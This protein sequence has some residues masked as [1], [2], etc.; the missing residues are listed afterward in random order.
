[1]LCRM[2]REKAELNSHSLSE[3]E[4]EIGGNFTRACY[5]GGKK[6]LWALPNNQAQYQGKPFMGKSRQ[7]H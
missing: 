6:S 4:M 1:M 7:V 5:L 3:R 2:Q